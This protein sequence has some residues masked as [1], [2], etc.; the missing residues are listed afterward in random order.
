MIN[1][2]SCDHRDSLCLSLEVT[3]FGRR[4]FFFPLFSCAKVGSK[5]LAAESLS[6]HHSCSLVLMECY[7]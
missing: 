6:E 5:C 4:H 1:V 3:A 7:L 2:S